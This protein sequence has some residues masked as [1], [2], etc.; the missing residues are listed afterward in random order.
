MTF[1]AQGR[2]LVCQ[3][4]GPG[5]KR[6]VA[7]IEKD[8][9]ETVLA[10]RYNGQPFFAP[11]DLCADRAG[12]VWFTDL[13]PDARG[14]AVYRIDAPGKVVRVVSNLLK[15][16]GIVLTSDG[17]TVYVSDRGTQKLHRYKVRADGGLNP[18]GVVYDFSPDRGI[19]GMRL[20]VKGNIYAAA[21]QGK[22]TG[23]FV[24]SPGGK[25]LLHYPTPEFATNLAFGGKDLRDLYFT[26]TRSVYKFRTVHPGAAVGPQKPA[27]Q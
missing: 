10:E 17:K 12:R 26:A 7:R 9:S 1:D 23:L 15:P 14:S 6:R 24:L 3:S 18:D 20:D 13:D 2:L 27:E 25:L 19:D 22:S 5:G 11:N 21:G 16:N 4:S 8:R